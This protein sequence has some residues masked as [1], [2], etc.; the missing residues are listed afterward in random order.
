[1]FFFCPSVDNRFLTDTPTKLFL[2]G[3]H[4]HVPMLSG[5]TNDEFKS[6]INAENDEDFEKKVREIFGDKA[7]KFLSFKEAHVKVGENNY[8][9]ADGIECAVK[10]AFEHN[11]KDCYY[12]LFNPD[13]PGWDNPG[14]F[15]SVDLWFFFETLGLCW[16]P[17]V[18]RHFDLARQIC[19]YLCNFAKTGDPNGND[20][21]G[22]PI[23]KWNPYTK[24]NKASMVFTPD[25]P[26]L[27]A[28]NSEFS[29]FI[30]EWLIE[31]GLK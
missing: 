10:G 27:T 13:I 2:E 5:N 16:R 24:E 29:E 11:D 15:H 12:Y 6:F 17:F 7:D 25:G 31:K 18:G 20:A 4:A 14:T 8:A 1:M 30:K 19:N 22:T 28:R 9:P 23:P 3:K 21:D 26:V